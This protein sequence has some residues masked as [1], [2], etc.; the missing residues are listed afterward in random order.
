MIEI[1]NI[2]DKISEALEKSLTDFI[3]NKFNESTEETFYSLAFWNFSFDYV[4]FQIPCLALN[5]VEFLNNSEESSKFIKWSPAN[6]KYP[7]LQFSSDELE[8]AYKDL[9]KYLEGKPENVWNIAINAVE[10]IYCCL[11]ENLTTWISESNDPFQKINLP[12]NFVIAIL[13][14]ESGPEEYER[15]LE[16]SVNPEL[17]DNLEDIHPRWSDNR[18]EK[19]SEAKGKNV[20]NINLDDLAKIIDYYKIMSNSGE[21]FKELLIFSKFIL[22]TIENGKFTEENVKKVK[23]LKPANS[24]EHLDVFYNYLV[25]QKSS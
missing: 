16:E 20:V 15:L 1:N 11:C 2:L 12:Q 3:I 5:S 7:N 23:S 8:A 22:D 21:R 25:S 18:K 13:Q 17:L 24:P 9:N 10:Q 6:W 4:S 14:T 19:E